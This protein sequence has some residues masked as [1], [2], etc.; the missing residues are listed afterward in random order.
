MRARVALVTAVIAAL[1]AVFLPAADVTPAPAAGLPTLPG[2]WPNAMVGTLPGV[3]M[4]GS[5]FEPLVVVNAKTAVG[6]A[7]STDAAGEQ[8]ISLV[9][10]T[11]DSARRLRDFPAGSPTRLAAVTAGNGAVSWV[12]DNPQATNGPHTTLWAADAAGGSPRLLATDN[13]DVQTVGPPYDLVLAD[14]RLHWMAFRVEGGEVRSAPASGGPVTAQVLPDVYSF[15]GWPW[16][17]TPSPGE[18]GPKHLLNLITGAQMD[19]DAPLNRVLACTPQWC[20]VSTVDYV[21]TVEVGVMHADG[22]GYQILTQFERLYTVGDQP[23]LLDRFEFEGQ[24]AATTGQPDTLWLVDVANGRRVQ[25]T[26]QFAGGF[27]SDADGHV[28]WSIAGNEGPTWQTLDL[29]T[30]S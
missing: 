18:H 4:D 21:K 15:I 9:L 20:R 6:R 19:I 29:R 23:M 10:A 25:A 24:K 26:T 17:A 13:D 3:L 1:A 2:V 7:T 16:L 30:L 8:T 5:T 28:W 27:G 22:S 14:G 11:P 12:E